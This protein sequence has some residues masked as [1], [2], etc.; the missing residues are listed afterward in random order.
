MTS[1]DTGRT[2][3]RHHLQGA[4]LADLAT[5]G[6]TTFVSMTWPGH[7]SHVFRTT[8][9]TRWTPVAP[10]SPAEETLPSLSPTTDGI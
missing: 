9:T 2:W 6:R 4:E 8:D 1:T 3:S 7:D 5:S 10:P